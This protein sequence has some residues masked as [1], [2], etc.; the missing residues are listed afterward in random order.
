[1]GNDRLTREIESHL[2]AFM[3]ACKPIR[4]RRD[5]LIAYSDLPTV[6]KDGSRTLVPEPTVQE[7]E[8]ALAPLRDFMNALEGAFCQVETAYEHFISR[9]DGDDLVLL[10]QMARRYME[11]QQAERIP[12]DD[13]QQSEYRDA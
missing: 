6:L 7:I 9:E 3:A 1:M 11:L 4:E 2:T 12:W 8:A 5:R 10:L 13:L